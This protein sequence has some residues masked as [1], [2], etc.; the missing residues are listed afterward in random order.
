MGERYDIAIIGSG[1][2]GLS[3][4]INAKARN[5]N[6]ILFGREELSEKLIKAHQ[7]NNYLG[8]YAKSGVEIAKLYKEHIKAMDIKITD[9]KVTNV[10]P[11]GDYYSL[12]TN[13]GMY[14]AKTVIIAT[15]VSFGKPI[16]GEKDYLGKGVSYCAT[17]DA[18]FYKGKTAAVIG[19]N[20]RDEKEAE[21]LAQ[22][23]A[24]VYYIP[25]YKQDVEISDT[26]EVIRD[27]VVG[28]HG[29]ES[30]K[31]LEL[32]NQSIDV[33]GV[34]ILRESVAAERLLPGLET[35]NGQIVADRLMRTNM[36]GCFVAGDVAGKPYQYIKAAG[37][38]NVAALSAVA[39]LEEH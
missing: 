9:E 25:M 20:K 2:A 23:A 12:L 30:V 7:V 17:C 13:E 5:K 29:D 16:S 22:V 32:K 38:G 21:F 19:Y 3:A 15:G 31:S 28:I 33:D 24:K 11:A 8:L 1:P 27:Q 37:D 39:Y 36:P 6:F 10:Y 26:I 4:A 35:S 34:F 14:E 18:F